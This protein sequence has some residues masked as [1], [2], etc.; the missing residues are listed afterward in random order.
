MKKKKNK[1]NNPPPPPTS[2]IS[3]LKP[4][5]TQLVSIKNEKV[6]R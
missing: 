2:H 6:I 3:Q 4:D 1:K 5:L